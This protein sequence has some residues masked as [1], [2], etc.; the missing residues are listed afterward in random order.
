VVAAW[1]EFRPLRVDDP[2]RLLTAVLDALPLSLYVVDRR[3]RVVAWNR[4][5]ETG[6]LG[7]PRSQV[8]GRPLEDVLSPQGFTAVLPSLERVF[9]TGLALEETT[10]TRQGERTFRVWRLPVLVGSEVTHVVSL[11]ED[12]TEQRLLEE[13]F[14]QAQTMEA[15]E[16]L[17]GAIAQDVN[18]ALTAIAGH[19]ELL[20]LGL[21]PQDG[22]REHAQGILGEVR[23]AGGVPEQLLAFSGR[24]VLRPSL[25][26]L[27][28]VLAGLDQMLR[29]VLGEAIELEVVRSPELGHV[30]VDQ[31]K[32]EQVLLNL[33]VNARDA[34]PGRG[35]FTIETANVELSE[36]DVRYRPGLPAGRYVMVAL[37]D[38]GAGLDAETQS[39]LF[40]P[41]FTT[42]S[43]A[44]NG[45]GLSTV[46]GIVGQSG[47]CVVVS[48]APGHGTTFRLYLPRV[49]E[50]SDRPSV[51]L[52]ATALAGGT[53]TILL[54]EDQD[55]VRTLARKILEKWGYRVLEAAH[56]L[57]A[58]EIARGHEGPIHLLLTDLSMPYMG[59]D[60][61]ARNLYR[62]RPETRLL[63]ISARTDDARLE[64]ALAVPGANF[65]PKP[66]TLGSLALK[67][68]QVLDAPAPAAAVQH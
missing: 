48:S 8:L 23:R 40:E 50:V 53:E 47:G 38:T 2:T 58:L 43:S 44:R 21:D 63:V 5:R 24:Q 12:V 68:R 41:F 17:A 35:R 30:S 60:D 36:A 62:W 7:R 15:M 65:M 28:T 29:R 4:Y 45:L 3:L 13:Q 10:E 32:I 46:H 55:A 39:H 59:G 33:A 37:T 61:L 20:M 16:R 56:G 31:G 22:R 9:D 64:E 42:R 52:D 34:M 18:T 27:N 11:F 67:V 66:F 1:E 6:P 19:A 25:T 51:P 54:A 14:R 26:N 49:I 57:E